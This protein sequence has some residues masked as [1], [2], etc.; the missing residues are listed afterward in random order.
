MTTKNNAIKIIVQY[1]NGTETYLIASSNVTQRLNIKF[2]TW[3]T[4][5][6]S[7][8]DHHSVDFQRSLSSLT[9]CTTRKLF[10]F[11]Y[12]YQRL[13]S[14]F[15]M[16]CSSNS[17][18][19]PK[20]NGGNL[21]KHSRYFGNFQKKDNNKL[22]LDEYCTNLEKTAIFNLQRSENLKCIRTQS[23]ANSTTSI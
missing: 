1:L 11:D 15:A 20:F 5:Y 3:S 14:T 16:F 2:L 12:R 17:I 13:F 8:D 4:I 18:K 21:L 6:L 19:K 22:D 9:S 10:V 23:D 7:V